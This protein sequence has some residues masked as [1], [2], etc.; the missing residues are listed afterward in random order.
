MYIYINIAKDLE[1]YILY[2]TLFTKIKLPA[3]AV[4][5]IMYTL[6]QC[7]FPLAKSKRRKRSF[8]LLTSGFKIA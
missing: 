8:L 5:D 4:L 7:R 2:I 6:M 3:L 1:C